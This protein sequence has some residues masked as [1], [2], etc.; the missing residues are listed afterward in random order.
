MFWIGWILAHCFDLGRNLVIRSIVC[1]GISLSLHA[2]KE[3]EMRQTRGDGC[4]GS[5]QKETN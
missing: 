2:L 1:G 5:K 4:F 3:T